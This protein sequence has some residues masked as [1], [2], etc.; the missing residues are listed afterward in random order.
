MT[1]V[2][3]S[4]IV[5]AP[6]EQV[7]NYAADYRKWPE[8]F[9]GVSDVKTT[10]AV[11][12]GNG[13]RYAYKVRIL[14]VSAG[15]ETE[16]HDFVLNRGWTGVSTKGVPHR[17]RWIFEPIG[18]TTRFTYAVEGHLPVPLLGSLCDSLFLKPQWDRIVQ[19]SLNNVKQHF[20]THGRGATE[21]SHDESD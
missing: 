8:W 2:E 16:I 15:V 7:F 5:Q 1:R 21:E 10:T 20:L 19:N 11:T 12:Q 14:A 4:V 3:N 6:V 18:S 9:E 17:T 13:A